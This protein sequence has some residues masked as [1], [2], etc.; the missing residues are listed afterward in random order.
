MRGPEFGRHPSQHM[1][2]PAR[3]LARIAFVPSLDLVI[4]RQTGSSGEWPFEE[5]L[6]LAC[7]AVTGP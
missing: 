5:F 4:T 3:D 6:R 7:A 1:G 2:M